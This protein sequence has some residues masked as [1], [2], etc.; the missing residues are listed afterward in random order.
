MKNP[1][2]STTS[3]AAANA[4]YESLVQL[5]DVIPG[6]YT[7]QGAA[8]TRLAFTSFPIPTL[9][10]VWVGPE[11][12]LGEVDAFAK[13]L[14]ATGMPWSIQVRGEV[15]PALRD[16]AARHGR[17][18]TSTT[19]LLVWDAELL[20]TL[21]TLIPEG[22]TVRKVPGTESDVLATA[23]AAGFDMPKEIADAFSL[24][25]LLDTPGMTA[26]VL[27]LHGEPVATGFNALVG[28]QVGMFNGSVPPRHRRHGYYR[29]LVTAR[30]RDAVAAG[31]QHAF[32]QNTPMSQPLYES[33]GF[34]VA[35]TWTY[36]MSAD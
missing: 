16:L 24:P 33:L 10:T 13:E 27:D 22:A 7:R 32:T 14:S 20:P 21:P 34:R 2:D 19:P 12:E 4:F 30:L 28:D 31:A 11:P 18:S 1:I 5:A 29:A 8:G 35:E 6:A 23:L 15:G 25:A 17:T 36:L 26:F 9:N 3:D